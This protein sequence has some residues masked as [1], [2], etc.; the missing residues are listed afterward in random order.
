[1][2]RVRNVQ[3]I[4]Y[5]EIPKDLLEQTKKQY[6]D[7]EG[8]LTPRVIARKLGRITESMAKKIA[9]EWDKEI[10]VR[11]ELSQETEDF[12][13]KGPEEFGLSEKERLFC[14]NYMKTF[15]K[16]TAA[17]AAGYSPN[18][19]R[20]ANAGK[21]LLSKPRI[22]KFLRKLKAQRDKELL[23]S[24]ID[25]VNQY[26]KIA[27]SDIT[28]V[29]EFGNKDVPMTDSY[30]NPCFDKESGDILTRNINYVKLKNINEVD[31]QLISEIKV[32]S[33]GTTV[34]M[35]DKLAAL[36]KLAQFFD[37]YGKRGLEDAKL[38]LMKD[39]LEL[40]RLKVIGDEEDEENQEGVQSFIK[41]STLPEDQVRD[42]FSGDEEE[43]QND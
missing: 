36:D 29:A 21:D 4:S 12:I 10:N 31:G 24:S 41:A 13:D 22:K 16:A 43:V 2:A 34:K 25:V 35:V 1:M 28:E 8:E 6:I 3:I 5:D 15:N 9:R 39:K 37:I 19:S 23:V 32:E 33:R 18:S 40:E 38:Q 30:G 26:V 11:I 42:L 20:N 27:F 7:C 14:F 17:V